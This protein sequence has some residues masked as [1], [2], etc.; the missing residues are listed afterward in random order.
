MHASRE[1]WRSEAVAELAK[2]QGI[3][4]PVDVDDL[5]G[6]GRDLWKSDAEFEEFVSGI[7]ERR[8]QGRHR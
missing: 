1:F 6:K 2:Q 8:R 3:K 5:I 4:L 7:Y